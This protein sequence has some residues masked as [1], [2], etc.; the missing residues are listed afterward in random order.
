MFCEQPEQ[1]LS[2]ATLLDR[3]SGL[4]SLEDDNAVEVDVKQLRQKLE[5]EGRTRVIHTI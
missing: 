2:K 1:V 5:V 3:A 4:G